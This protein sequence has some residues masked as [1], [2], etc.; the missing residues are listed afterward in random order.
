MR[1]RFAF[2]KTIT[3][4]SFSTDPTTSSSTSVTTTAITTITDMLT[5]LVGG[6]KL[7]H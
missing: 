3:N 6:R 2:R 5:S 1:T 4:D 7:G